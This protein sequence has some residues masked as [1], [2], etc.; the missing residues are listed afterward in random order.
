M[1]YFVSL[2]FFM[3]I[4]PIYSFGE[5]DEN[6]YQQAVN[7]AKAKQDTL[8]LS[9]AYYKLGRF[10][11]QNQQIEN[12]NQAMQQALFWAELSQKNNAIAAVSNYLAAN[13]SILGK[14]DSAY[15]FYKKALEATQ[16]DGDSLKMAV[17]LMNMADDFATQG[18]F[19]QAVEFAIDA[20][21][22]KE[23]RKD[24]ARLAFFYQ[25]VG[26][27]YKQADEVDNWERYLLKAYELRNC[28]TC[29]SVP[30]LAAIY[31]D[32]GGIAEKRQQYE[33]ALRY[34]DTLTSIGRQ[35]NYPNAIGTALTNTAHIYKL[36][37]DVQ[38][39]LKTALEAA[40]FKTQTPYQAIIK[41][42]LLADLYLVTGSPKNALKFAQQSMAIPELDFYPE[43]K[44]RTQK[45]LY[46]IYK[47]QKNYPQAL[48]W[49]EA[50]VKFSDSLRSTEIR[51]QILE[52]ELAY[53]TEKK[54]QRIALLTAENLIKSQRINL[55]IALLAILA[56]F[57]LLITYILISRKKQA[58]LK[59]NNLKQQVLRAQMNPHFIFNVL[60]SIQ[61]FMMNNEKQ[62]AANYLAQF[63]G[64]TR[65][66][67]NNSTAEAISLSDEIEML[68]NYIELEKMRSGYK[69]DFS[70]QMDNDLETDLIQVPPMLVQ[71]FVEN[72]I[73]HGFADLNKRGLLL[74]KITDKGDA[75]EFIIEDNG[76]GLKPKVAKAKAYPSKATEIFNKRRKLIQQKYQKEFKFETINLK[77]QHPELSG[78][79]VVIHIPIIN[80]Y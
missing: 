28:D 38:K 48:A 57:V 70:L 68:C 47:A 37:G 65:A 73:K 33:S 31:N 77:D 24:S 71:P 61:N 52:M 63:A 13:Y 36:Q 55:G 15:I 17:I 9:R 4:S 5:A 2:L 3:L 41:N 30:A 7:E 20:I 59:E 12:S 22:I 25:K 78:L 23:T 45:V 8:G 54:E 80:D 40:Q 79:R 18:R 42:N 72:A 69:F 14:V 58:E 64:L 43:E 74:L 32:L 19:A 44:M 39:A 62:D 46:Q 27:I 67:L 11:D 16:N 26:E 56:V 49:H 35:Y 53:E 75:I 66:T 51:A 50:A 34:Y 6:D 21:R 10:Y 1:P 60:G 76:V 29:A